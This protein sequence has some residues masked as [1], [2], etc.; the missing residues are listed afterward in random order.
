MHKIKV[1]LL[2]LLAVPFLC[3][4]SGRSISQLLFNAQRAVNPQSLLFQAAKQGSEEAAEQLLDLADKAN[5]ISWIKK[6]VNLGN[7]RAAWILVKHTDSERAA[8]RWV[9]VAA[10]GDVPEAQ[11]QYAMNLEDGERRESWLKKAA[12]QSYR[13]AELA[14]ADWYLLHQQP[15]KAKPWLFNT[16]ETD[17]KSAFQLGRLLWREEAHDEARKYIKLAADAGFDIAQRYEVALERYS[18]QS[19]AALSL[20]NP[21]VSAKTCHQRIQLIATGIASIEQAHRFYQAFHQDE[22]LQSLPICLSQPVWLKE[23]SVACDDNWQGS[24]RLGCDLQPLETFARVRQFTHAVI[25]APQGKANVHNGV[26]YLDVGDTYSVFIHEL[27]HFAGF[28]DEY[29]MSAALAEVYCERRTAPNLVFNGQIT[30]APLANI[31]R[32]SEYAK[33][34]QLYPAR[35][36]NNIDVPSYKPSRDITFMENHDSHTIPGLYKKIWQWQLANPKAQRPIALNFFQ[37]FE[38]QGNNA[39]AE[40]WLNE[41]RRIQGVDRTVSQDTVRSEDYAD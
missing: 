7:A 28:V 9:Q 4:D 2:V 32:W 1:V 15:D 30:Y 26:M 11:F 3:A 34:V 23:G 13:P 31:R 18:E 36:C 38:K 20:T 21:W 35:T 40:Y 10:Y 41:F 29:P 22:R 24:G 12:E 17:A 25:F 33:P 19:L 14:L 6:L 39:K 16:A 27:A 8:N 5:Q 37:L